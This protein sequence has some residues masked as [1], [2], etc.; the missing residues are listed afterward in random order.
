M[1]CTDI[2]TNDSELFAEIFGPIGGFILLVAIGYYIII[3]GLG[4]FP[5]FI[6]HH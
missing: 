1:N 3:K 5:D 6:C 2:E 4:E